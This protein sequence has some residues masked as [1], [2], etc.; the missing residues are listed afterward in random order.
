[1]ESRVGHPAPPVTLGHH[2]HLYFSH[3][4]LESRAWRAGST[5]VDSGVA[6]GVTY[7]GYAWNGF[8]AEQDLRPKQKIVRL[9]TPPPPLGEPKWRRA[10]ALPRWWASA[11]R[12]FGRR[13]DISI[14]TA[15]S[16]AA[17]PVGVILSRLCGAGL[18]YDAHE[19]E[20]ERSGWPSPVRS[21][22]KLVERVLIGWCDHTVVVNDT[23][24][25]WYLEHY[26]DRPI[27]TV[28]NVPIVPRTTGA[29]TLRQQL[30]I[31]E[32]D[33][34]CIYCGI[35]TKGRFLS[36]LVE[37]FRDLPPSHHLVLIGFGPLE[38][39]IRQ[40]AR[41]LPNVHIVA[42]VPQEQLI[43]LMSGGDIG[44]FFTNRD[45]GSSYDYSL[46]NKVFEYAGAKLGL[47]VGTGP[48]LVRFASDY[49]WARNCPAEIDAVRNLIAEIDLADLRA[50]R[51][52]MRYEPPSWTSESEVLLDVYRDVS[53]KADRR[54]GRASSSRK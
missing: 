1:M 29:S 22:A 53:A 31:P 9:G 3:W 25:G 15:H 46:P 5:A 18:L 27:T 40:H 34:V 10:I 11:I 17:L 39:S 20:T 41:D 12:G 16:L 19:L 30:G 8:P 2:L 52:A 50:T 21:V 7:V 36:E 54:R 42:A 6:T 35:L 14:V 44:L 37:V 45:A 51:A 38:E 23:I 28:R 48:E 24:R 26:G 49:P 43:P 32:G 4:E 13:R 33:L 47:V